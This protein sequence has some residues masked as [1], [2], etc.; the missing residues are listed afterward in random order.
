[1]TTMPTTTHVKARVF[2]RQQ[3]REIALTYA[4]LKRGQK[5]PYAAGW[6]LTRK[7][8]GIRNAR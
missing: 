6:L 7:L 8:P 4:G 5:G 2:T 1:M 3:Q